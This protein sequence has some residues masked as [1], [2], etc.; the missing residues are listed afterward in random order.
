MSCRTPGHRGA[1]R[2]IAVTVYLVT[3]VLTAAAV[4]AAVWF[5][6]AAVRFVWEHAL[7]R[8]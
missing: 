6:V 7:A 3:G 1:R 5:G 8:M 2:T 4:T